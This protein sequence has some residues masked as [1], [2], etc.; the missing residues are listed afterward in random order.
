MKHQYIV[1]ETGD[2]ADEEFYHD[3]LVNYLYSFMREEH[4]LVYRLVTSR[5]I[6]SLMAWVNYDFPAGAWLSGGSDF[7]E[8][9]GIDI[10]EFYDP[11]DTLDTARKFFERK[12]RY[13]QCRPMPAGEGIIVSPADSR[14]I[15]GSFE[16]ESLLFLKENF[17]SLD[18]LLGRGRG[19]KS[20]FSNGSYAVFRLTPDKYHYSHTP[21][22]GIVKD[23][24]EIDGA[25][26]S[27]NPGAVIAVTDAYSKNRRSVTVFDTDVSGGSGAGMVAMIEVAALMIGDIVQCYSETLYDNPVP[28][29]H[30]MFLQKG[31]PKSLFRP[32]SSVDILL[33]EKGRMEFDRDLVENSMKSGVETRY[34]KKFTRPVV[35]TDIKVRSSIGSAIKRGA[36]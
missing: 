16:T 25:Y 18:D 23:Y 6:S 17:F 22:S 7:L 12:I 30:G 2:V 34:M 36:E 9:S 31:Q 5:W 4:S 24:Y 28:L 8:R 15:T 26:N 10:S 11:V 29:M 32:G 13:T 33:F 21:V 20:L 1:R 35:E 19:W 3:N 27:C 14:V